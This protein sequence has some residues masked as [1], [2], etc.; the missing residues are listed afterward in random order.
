MRI[1]GLISRL[2]RPP[3]PAPPS[4]Q[5]LEDLMARLPDG[6]F[7]ERAEVVSGIAATGDPRAAAVLEALGEG[8]LHRRKDD[9]AIIRVTGRGA[10]RRRASTPLTGA[11]LGPVAA[12]STEAIRVNNAL[13][14]AIRAGA[15][16][17][18]ADGP[19]PGQA[20]RRRRPRRS[21]TP[22]PRA[23]PRSTPRIAAETDAGGPAR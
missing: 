1:I 15:R 9:G 7:N 10:E 16:D 8:E 21:R 11:E 13:R 3:R 18:D 17:P 12:R 4:A 20:D 14:R 5:T 19:R 2:A 6:N 23:S 22:T